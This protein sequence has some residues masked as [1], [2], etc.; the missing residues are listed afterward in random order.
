ML[1]GLQLFFENKQLYQIWFFNP[2]LQSLDQ[3]ISVL[4]WVR[5]PALY[6]RLMAVS[7]LSPVSIQTLI[8]SYYCYHC[9]CCYYSDLDPGHPEVPDGLHHLLLQPVLYPRDPDQVQLLLHTR[10]HLPHKLG[11]EINQYHCNCTQINV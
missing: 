2:F 10:V 6:P 1:K 4:S 7:F 9:Y 8:Y 5:S 11:S 3:P